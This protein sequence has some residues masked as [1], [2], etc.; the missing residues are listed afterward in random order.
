MK[1][2]SLRFASLL[3]L[4]LYLAE[5]SLGADLLVDGGR[6]FEPGTYDAPGDVLLE[7]DTHSFRF[8]V[9]SKGSSD[10]FDIE[11]VLDVLEGDVDLVV[12]GPVMDPLGKSEMT[13]AY[14]VSYLRRLPPQ[15]TI[16]LFKLMP[17]RLPNN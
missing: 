1:G 17:V 4:L 8:N 3:L 2:T 16:R 6:V 14:R 12:V 11:V 5:G 7:G 9:T 15:P 13:P 10:K